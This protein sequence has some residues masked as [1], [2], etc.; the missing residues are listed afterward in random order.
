MPLKVCDVHRLVDNDTTLREC[1]WCNRCQAWI[2]REDIPRWDRRARAMMKMWGNPSGPKG[3]DI[4]SLTPPVT[5]P[6]VAKTASGGCKGC[7]K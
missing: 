7:G 2:C 6:G 3:K 5:L 4:K 1:V